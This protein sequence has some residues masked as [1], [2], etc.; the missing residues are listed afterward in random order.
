MCPLTVSSRFQS[1]HP[2]RG[3]TPSRSLKRHLKRIFQS[4]HP[5][6][7]ATTTRTDG[8]A[9]SCNFNPRTPCGVRLSSMGSEVVVLQISIHAPL[10]GCDS[11]TASPKTLRTISIHAPLA[12]CDQHQTCQ[13]YRIQISIH[14]PLAGRDPSRRLSDRCDRY[15]NP[16]TPCGARPANVCRAALVNGFQSTHPL[17]GATNSNVAGGFILSISIHAPLAGRDISNAPTYS[18]AWDFNPRTPCGARQ[19]I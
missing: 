4:T 13:G 6:R 5:L 17:R 8:N 14:A 11:D 1:T 9:R 2:L 10:A 12:G 15:F 3:A 7:G 19:Q 16:R 18:I